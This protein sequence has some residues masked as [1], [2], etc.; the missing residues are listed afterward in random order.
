M[1]E[2]L[3]KIKVIENG[4]WTHKKNITQVN[5]ITKGLCARFFFFF[6]C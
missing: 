5:V 3:W 1:C 2:K 6:A 4:D